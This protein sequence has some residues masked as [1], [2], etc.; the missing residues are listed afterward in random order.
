VAV[1][2]AP[3]SKYGYARVSLFAIAAVLLCSTAAEAQQALPTIDVGRVNK[4]VT[5][6]TGPRTTR[7]V[8]AAPAAVATP[9]TAA[10]QPGI[11]APAPFVPT[12]M[13]L[14]GGPSGVVGYVAHGTST[15]TKTQTP[16]LDIPQSVTIVTQK[17]LQDRASFSLNQALS[18]VPGVTVTGGEGNKDAVSIRGQ[19][20]SADF[21]RDGIRDDAEYYRDLYNIEAVEVLKGP[22]ALTFGRGGGG[23]V[24]N[25]VTKKAD[26]VERRDMEVTFGSFGRKRVT[27]DLGQ[28]ISDQFAVRLNSLYEQSYGYRNFFTMERYGVN[29]TLTWKPQQNTFVTLG[30]EHYYDRR[31]NDR[32]IPSVGLGSFYDG[33]PAGLASL[34]PGYPAPT[35]NWTFFGNAFPS[36][37]TNNYSRANVNIVDLYMEHKADNGLE[38]KNHTLY[39]N[40]AKRY[41]NTFPGENVLFFEGPPGGQMEIEGYQHNVPRTNIFNQTDLIYRYQMTPDIKHT[42]LAGAEVG[43]QRSASERNL[44]CFGPTPS[45]DDAGNSAAAVAAMLSVSCDGGSAAVD[46]PFLRPTLYQAMIYGDA[47]ERRY[48]D[49]N[50]A[51]GYVQDQIAITEHLD[52]LAGVRFDHFDLNF[53]GADFPLPPAAT[54]ED[55]ATETAEGEIVDPINQTIHSVT[56]K[57]S[58]RLGAVIKPNKDLSY[59]FAYSR[60]FLPPASDQFVVLT[61]SLAALQPQ[62]FQN[63]EVGMKYQILPNLLFT[64]ALYQLNRSNQ[65]I[66]VT[67]FN[68]VSANTRTRGGELG[69][70]GNVTEQWQVSLGYGLQSARILNASTDPNPIDPWLTYEGKVTPN[71]PRNTFSYWN[72]VDVSSFLDADAGVVG[73]GAG[74][75][76]NAQFYPAAD[77]TVIVP[78]YARVDAAAYLKITK[79]ISAQVNVEN[80]LGAHYYV[81]ASNNNNIMPGAPQSAYLTVNGKF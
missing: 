10:A 73:L 23:G 66:T 29:P 27:V 52:I 21:Y 32:G 30:Y 3:R 15:A 41:A 14:G 31:F 75:I 45:D 6:A 38:I 33:Y 24:I 34:V 46:A 12:G 79:N 37:T 8:N 5:H 25:R 47:R 56:N 62:G 40:Y 28:A 13:T 70:V 55:Q 7:P 78:G 36:P 4:R 22:S 60:S 43:N 77:N 9:S 18:Y 20:S 48:T 49:L 71:V 44:S 69:L 80:L 61:P 39:A 59:Y 68:S 81:A 76:Y 67:A 65:P 54:L 57:W 17:Q 2:V 19:N 51:S 35:N 1:F 11:S 53:T 16:I 50:V 58:P 63:I 42:L 64:A 74:V 72:K 26:G